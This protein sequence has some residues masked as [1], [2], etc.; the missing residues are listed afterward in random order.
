MLTYLEQD[1]AI[2]TKL[3]ISSCNFFSP[4]SQHIQ[5][6]CLV[7]IYSAFKDTVEL[8]G[9][10]F[11]SSHFLFTCFCWPSLLAPRPSSSPL[12]STSMQPFETSFYA[13][14]FHNSSSLNHC[15]L[16]FKS[17]SHGVSA[18]NKITMALYVRI[19]V[20]TLAL[21]GPLLEETKARKELSNH[22]H[23]YSFPSGPLVFAKIPWTQP[24]NFY[25]CKQVPHHMS[26]TSVRPRRK[27]PEIV[28]LGGDRKSVV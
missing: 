2:S 5:F 1:Q 6:S 14:I 3:V 21:S 28:G 13:N 10:T 18:E 7:A 17:I 12:L 24:C 9:A 8:A 22:P 26:M 4:L 11:S 20:Y 23:P 15:L 19:G 25:N 16:L 27:G